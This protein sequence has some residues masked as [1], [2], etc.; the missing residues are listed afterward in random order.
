MS[1]IGLVITLGGLVALT[2]TGIKYARKQDKLA[3]EMKANHNEIWALHGKPE[4]SIANPIASLQLSELIF[5]KA[6]DLGG[7]GLLLKLHKEAR[8]SFLLFGSNFGL[9]FVGLFLLAV[10][11][12]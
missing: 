1:L 10:A 8:S 5:K 6:P 9:V 2:F 11:G 3:R 4:I 7:V 12:K